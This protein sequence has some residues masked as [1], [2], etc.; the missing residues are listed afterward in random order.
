MAPEPQLCF[1]SFRAVH[2]IA[3]LAEMPGLKAVVALGLPLG[4]NVLPLEVHPAQYS[5]TAIVAIQFSIMSGRVESNVM[6]IK[7]CHQPQP[8][9]QMGMGIGALVL[10]LEQQWQQHRRRGC[11]GNM[12]YTQ[13]GAPF[14]LP[15]SIYPQHS[16]HTSHMG[17]GVR[18]VLFDIYLPFWTT[19]IALQKNYLK[20]GTVTV[21]SLLHI[22]FYLIESI[23][24]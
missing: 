5:H 19:V 2:L 22:H 4:S 21:L 24:R 8:Q 6:L 10:Q 12:A 15:T 23:L 18:A 7:Y 14:V 3:S 11:H 16:K 20:W 17:S 13:R 1:A 9:L